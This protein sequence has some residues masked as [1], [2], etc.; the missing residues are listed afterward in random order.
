MTVPA[1]EQSGWGPEGGPEEW[2]GDNS[3]EGQNWYLIGFG[4]G[5]GMGTEQLQWDL[6]PVENAEPV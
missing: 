5:R 6:G 4:V 1:Y 3:F 2:G